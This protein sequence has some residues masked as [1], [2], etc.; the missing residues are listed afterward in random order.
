[1]NS[2][3]TPISHRL[4]LYFGSRF[5][6]IVLLALLLALPLAPG[7]M[8]M[9]SPVAVQA[10]PVPGGGQGGMPQVLQEEQGAESK[11]TSLFRALR[12]FSLVLLLI[13]CVLAGVLFVM[14]K[15][16]MAIGVLA[17]AII[18]GGAPT[19]IEMIYSALQGGQT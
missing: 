4:P 17:A 2:I 10:Q 14:G 7:A 8:P 12:T 19:V 15:P 11:F 9:L 5:F 16:Q 18:I 1:M 3:I 13:G 6:K